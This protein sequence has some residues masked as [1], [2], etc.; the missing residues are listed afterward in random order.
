MTATMKTKETTT[1]ILTLETTTY[2]TRGLKAQGFE[3]VIVGES[4]Q[5]H[6]STRKPDAS[7]R[8]R[9]VNRRRRG[10]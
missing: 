3:G 6:G 7:R 10:S 9:R 4:L 8:S 2:S 1:M 5:R